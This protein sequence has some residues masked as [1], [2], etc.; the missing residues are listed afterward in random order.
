MNIPNDCK[1]GTLITG[2]ADQWQILHNSLDYRYTVDGHADVIMNGSFCPLISGSYTISIS[3]KYDS[4]YCHN[5]TFDSQ[6]GYHQKTI[7]QDL[8][9]GKCYYFRISSC[10]M[11]EASTTLQVTINGSSYIPTIPEI[12]TCSIKDC[13]NGGNIHRNCLKRIT[14]SCKISKNYNLHIFLYY[15]VFF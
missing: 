15:I 8:Y 13:I 7:H 4:D 5:Y 3:G 10:A 2:W 14:S 1:R 9:R 12:Y 11:D 6:S